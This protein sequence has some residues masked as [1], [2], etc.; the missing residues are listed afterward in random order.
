MDDLGRLVPT[1]GER[2]NG[3][4]GRLVVPAR[5]GQVGLFEGLC[6][7]ASDDSGRRL[8]SIGVTQRMVKVGFF[9]ERRQCLIQGWFADPFTRT[10]IQ[11]AEEDIRKPFNASSR[12][13]KNRI[14][15]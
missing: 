2:M 9:V 3:N 4:V 7:M 5:H 6:G 15:L 10:Q 13:L 12:A 14:A 1:A 11:C 8:A